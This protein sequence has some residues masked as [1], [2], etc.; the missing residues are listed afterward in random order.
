[1]DEGRR[2]EDESSESSS[3]KSISIPQ[4]ELVPPGYLDG[5]DRPIQSI[6]HYDE[7][8]FSVD[9]ATSL[10]GGNHVHEDSDGAE[11]AQNE[12]LNDHDEGYNDVDSEEESGTQLNM[13]D[14]YESDDDFED[15]FDIESEYVAWYRRQRTKVENIATWPR[16]IARAHK[17]V[18]LRGLYPLMPT[19][20]TWDLIDHPS[21]EGL[22][23]PASIGKR[24]I[25]RE[26]SN[27]FRGR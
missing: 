22:F 20:W 1:M 10:R 11:G 24:L 25:L 2:D 3:A 21:V 18:A 26:H 5:R 7:N 6:E 8:V 17:C 27:H 9:A 16:E 14:Y 15:E 12:D 19:P 4:D 13:D 23:A